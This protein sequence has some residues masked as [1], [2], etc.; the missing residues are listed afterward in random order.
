MR[1][2]L[3]CIIFFVGSALFAQDPVKG[4]VDKLAGSYLENGNGALVIGVKTNGVSHIYYYGKKASDK[5]VLPDS[6]D[7]FEIG[8]ITETFTSIVLADKA[9]KGEMSIDGRLQD[10]LDANVPAVV[11]QPFVC[12]PVD[13][14]ADPDYNSGDDYLRV[15]FK[16]IMCLPDSTYEPQPVLL[17]YLAS[18]TSGM[19]DLPNNLHSKINDQPL[20]EYS[21]DDLYIF[22]NDYHIEKPVGFDYNPSRLGIALLGQAISVRLKK[23][24]ETILTECILD[25]LRMNSS[26]ISLSLEQQVRVLQG[27]NKKGVKTAASTFKAFAPVL[28]LHSTPTDMMK[29]L[30]A[31]ISIGKDHISNVLDYTHNPRLK[32]KAKDDTEI[33]LGWKINSVTDKG[34]RMVWQSGMTNGFAAF[35]G[36]VETNHF[37][38]FVLSSKAKSAD[39]LGKELIKQIVSIHE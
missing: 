14:G 7:I 22:L 39:D 9:M 34:E 25:S 19:P 2:Y 13:L 12:K 6:S 21:K 35:I 36:F 15:K 31:N 16:P 33:A 37:G 5:N 11:Y 24:Y 30:S 27:H 26:S 28:G 17:C 8:G 29:F 1:Y 10:Y 3:S 38:V 20:A 32:A 18:H 23:D 4:L